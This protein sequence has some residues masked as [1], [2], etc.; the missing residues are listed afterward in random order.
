LKTSLVEVVLIL[1]WV[2]YLY[3]MSF[4]TVCVM[5]VWRYYVSRLL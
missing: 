1:F 5:L 2:M 3:H 4:A